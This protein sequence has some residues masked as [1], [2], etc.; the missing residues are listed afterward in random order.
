MPYFR[1][2]ISRDKM[3]LYVLQIDL[4]IGRLLLGRI[5]F[6]VLASALLYDISK[7]EFLCNLVDYSKVV[8]E[9]LTRVL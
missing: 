8:M 9:L 2:E 4:L 1:R 7:Y 6:P 3:L 5:I